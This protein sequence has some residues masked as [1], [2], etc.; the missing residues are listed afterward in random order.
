MRI[1]GSVC[2]CKRT[3]IYESKTG[4]ESFTVK[5]NTCLSWYMGFKI[6]CL[7]TVKWDHVARSSYIK[8][9]TKE[10]FQWRNLS[11][12]YCYHLKNHDI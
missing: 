6:P 8:L 4:Q 11:I 9:Q 3:S 7:Y 1:R 2:Q 5:G 12:K 10:G